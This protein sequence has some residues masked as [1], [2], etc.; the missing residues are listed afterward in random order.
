MAARIRVDYLLLIMASYL[1]GYVVVLCAAEEVLVLAK[2]RA[3]GEGSIRK[4]KD[5]RWEG[6][7]TVGHDPITGKVITK[8]VL[9][10]TQAECREKLKAELNKAEILDYSKADK[11]TVGAWLDTWYNNYVKTT[12]RP[13]TVKN[14]ET[15]IRLHIKPTIGDI[16][17]KQLTPTFLQQLYARLLECGR[18]ERPESE[19]QPKGLSVKTVRNI[20][21]IVRSACEKAVIERLLMFNP[22]VGCELPR[23]ERK[24]MKTLPLDQLQTFFA[25]AKKY[26]SF[27][28]FYLELATGLRRGELLGLKWSDI[29]FTTG[30]IR[31]QRQVQR[32]DGKVQEVKL[33][34]DN[35]YRTI[36]VE[37]DIL[38][39]LQ[40]MKNERKVQSE[41]VFCSPTGGILEPGAQRKKLQ[42]LLKNCG[43]EK[44]RFHDLRHTF[45]TLALQNGVDVKTLSGILGHYSAAFTLDTYGHISTQMQ[46]DAAQKVGGFLRSNVS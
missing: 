41:Y 35:A 11:I 19:N 37:K 3:N 18:V 46:Q 4:R 27:E 31:I 39:M 24:E 6:R 42:I 30:A 7:F 14:Y 44:I 17:L 2:K 33:K 32:V 5:G 9:A 8:N 43:M 26:G 20:H 23:K 28:M 16:P 40:N 22:A 36:M 38:D 10:R 13:S 29:N 21:T 15:L 1:G 45:A 25:A 34:T 12:L